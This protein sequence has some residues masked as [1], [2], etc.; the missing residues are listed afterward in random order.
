MTFDSSRR[1]TVGRVSKIW[2]R[3]VASFVPQSACDKPVVERFGIPYIFRPNLTL[4]EAAVATVGT[5]CRLF[6]GWVLFAF[7]GVATWIA[8]ERLPNLFFRIAATIPLAIVFVAILGAM[9]IGM[10]L[11]EEWLLPRHH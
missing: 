7:F 8:W 10:A 11:L 5:F 3:V 2:T 6:F 1:G 9:M 4:G